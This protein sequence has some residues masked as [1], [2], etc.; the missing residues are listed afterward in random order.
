MG[1][2]VNW[3]IALVS[4]LVAVGLSWDNRHHRHVWRDEDDR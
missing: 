4:L 3:I 1:D 2:P